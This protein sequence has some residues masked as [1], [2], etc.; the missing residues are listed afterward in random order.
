MDANKNGVLDKNELRANQ[1]WFEY[2]KEAICEAYHLLSYEA[3]GPVLGWCVC[4]FE[5][6]LLGAYLFVLSFSRFPYGKTPFAL[7][8]R[9]LEEIA[10]V[11]KL[12]PL[13]HPGNNRGNVYLAT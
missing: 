2:Y 9:A 12:S 3:L 1:K 11:I 8:L 13:L 7:A 4:P 5:R 6:G 10:P